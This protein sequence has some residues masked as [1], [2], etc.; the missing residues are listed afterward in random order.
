MVVVNIIILVLLLLLAGYCGKLK[1]QERP[2]S[3]P[4]LSLN[5]VVLQVSNSDVMHYIR[6]VAEH[7]VDDM[8]NKQIDFNYKCTP[9]S[10]MGW[11]D[12]DAVEKGTILMLTEMCT[13]TPEHGRI[14]LEAFA[15]PT[16]DT[17]TIRINDSSNI[18]LRLSLVIVRQLVNLHHGSLQS[19]FYEGQGNMVIAQLPI[20]KERYVKEEILETRQGE[21]ELTISPSVFHIPNNIQ[22]NIPTIEL[23]EGVSDGTQ[24]LGSLVQ[25]AYNSPDQKFLQRAIKCINEHLDDSDYD[26]ESFAADMGASASTLYNKLRALTGKNVTAFIRDIRIQTACKLAKENPELRVSD[27]AYQVGFKDPKYFAT[28]FKKVMGV[29]PRDYF[30]RLRLEH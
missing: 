15:N 20:K 18:P 3:D 5:R 21:Q 14:T 28:T 12:I 8:E 22:L 2:K 16:Y 30:E 25:Q 24:S 29:Q 7:L 23:P 17:I 6:D 1:L 9:E 27:I 13:N 19:V 10:M 26:R 11:V 4:S